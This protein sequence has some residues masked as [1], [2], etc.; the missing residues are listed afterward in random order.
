MH[1]ELGMC[2]FLL[3]GGVVLMP[4]YTWL[5]IGLVALNV[6][7]I[8]KV[9]FWIIIILCTIIILYEIDVAHLLLATQVLK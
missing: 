7:Q 9:Q 8:T 6:I 3:N 4:V 2:F 1:I 5:V